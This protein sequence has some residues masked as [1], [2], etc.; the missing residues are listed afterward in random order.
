MI[1]IILIVLLFASKSQANVTGD[2][3]EFFANALKSTVEGCPPSECVYVTVGRSPSPLAAMLEIELAD[4]TFNMPF[5]KF[6][7][8]HPSL[9]TGHNLESRPFMTA[10]QKTVFR[11][12]ISQEFGDLSRFEGKRVVLIDYTDSGDSLVTAKAHLQ[13]LLPE[14]S[15]VEMHAFVA[16]YDGADI[17]HLNAK[18]PNETFEK[19]PITSKSVDKEFFYSSFRDYAKRSPVSL[20]GKFPY[21]PEPRSAFTKMKSRLADKMSDDSRLLFVQRRKRLADILSAQS[22]GSLLDLVED[23]SSRGVDLEGRILPLICN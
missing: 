13:E 1:R 11:D 5:S 17:N 10:E 6:K 2:T 3:Y 7:Y 21:D 12:T 14:S 22:K 23:L 8:N 4:Q 20:D 15:K 19:I 9:G 18:F 16:A